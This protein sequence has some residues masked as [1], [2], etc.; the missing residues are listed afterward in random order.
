MVPFQ[1]LKLALVL[2]H[3]A[4]QRLLTQSKY[5]I[6]CF[7]VGGEVFAHGVLVLNA[8]STYYALLEVIAVEECKEFQ[9]H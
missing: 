5:E 7:S 8:A 4:P 6:A 1:Y 9:V 3:R 2:F